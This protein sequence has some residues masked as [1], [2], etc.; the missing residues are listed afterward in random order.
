MENAC[1]RPKWHSIYAVL[2]CIH[3]IPAMLASSHAI[4]RPAAQDDAPS[5]ATVHIETWQHAYRGQLPD[6][7]LDEL[8]EQR[9]RRTEFWRHEISDPRSHQHEIWIVSAATSVDGF[10]A[11]GPERESADHTT[12][13]IYAIYVNPRGWNQ[14][15]GRALMA[16]A[17][18]RLALLRHSAAILWV[19]ESNTRARRFYELAGWA[20]D[21]KI[22]LETLP[23]GVE[24]REMRYR[25]LLPNRKEE[26]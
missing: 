10:V 7:Y 22:K 5:I 14:G 20:T 26:S 2:Q 4:V 17:E 15:L 12:G 9:A 3:D 24:L 18:Q 23:A 21:G 11:F 19:L 13:E 25:K 6:R 16:K 8:G 1:C